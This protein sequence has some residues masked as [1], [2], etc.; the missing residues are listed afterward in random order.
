M[1][2]QKGG[3]YRK[4]CEMQMS[5]RKNIIIE[6]RGDLPTFS[7]SAFENTVRTF[8][9]GIFKM[10]KICYSF[11]VQFGIA[12]FSTPRDAWGY[13]IFRLLSRNAIGCNA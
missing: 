5:Q 10:Q 8:E 9:H 3:K 7:C 6:W 1:I 13:N 12:N 2:F 11:S 4:K